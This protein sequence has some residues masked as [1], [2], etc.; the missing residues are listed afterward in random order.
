VYLRQSKTL[1]DAW[2][3]RYVETVETEAGTRR[4]QR[5]VRLGDARQYTKPLAKRALRDYV[6][7]ANEYQPLAAKTQMM[8]KASTPFSVFAARWQTEVLVHKKA[9]TAATIKG[10]I[11]RLLIP[12]FGNMAIGDLDSER[13]QSFLNRLVGKASPKT[14]KNVWTT[15]RIMWNSAVAWKYVTGELR[16]ELPKARKLR[17]RCYAVEEVKRILAH[18]KGADRVFFWL[19]AE[20]GLRAGELIALRAS[21]VDVETLSVEVTKAIWNGSEDNPKTEA[22]FRSVCI[23]SRLGSQVKEYLAGRTDG[24]LFQTSSGNPWGASNVLE[25]KLNTVLERLDIPKIDS[26]LLAKFVGR[27]RTIE[28]A[29]RSEKRAASLGLHSFRHTAATAMDSLGIPQ[30]IRRQRLGHSGNSVTDGYTHTFSDDERNAAEKL[31]ELFGTGWPE[32]DKGKLISFPS[33]SQKE[34]GP[35]G[36]SQQALVNQ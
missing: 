23:S 22:A 34:E 31:G 24:Y 18:T 6:D 33:L 29:T 13:V 30:Q 8:G 7:K 19:A 20:S 5:N 12:V 25:R 15:L 32:I 21:D 26:K 2:W 14:V 27:E 35:V 28:Q 17:M 1:P 11:N 10:H 16:V 4:I 36:S 9:S 3:G